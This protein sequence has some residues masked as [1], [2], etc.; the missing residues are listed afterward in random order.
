[1]CT[2]NLYFEQ[3]IFS[4][5]FSIFTGEKNLCILY[6]QV[7][8]MRTSPWLWS[9][10]QVTLK[11]SLESSPISPGGNVRVMKTKYESIVYVMR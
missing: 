4:N 3:N 11:V 1:M 9:K 8:V 6:G 7:F 10:Q 2:H 5:K